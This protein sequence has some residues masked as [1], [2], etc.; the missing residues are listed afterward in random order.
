MHP[1]QK[2]ID[3]PFPY[4]CVWLL[5]RNPDGIGRGS[6]A[7]VTESYL[8]K[9]FVWHDQLFGEGKGKIIAVENEKKVGFSTF[10]SYYIYYLSMSKPN[11][12]IAVIDNSNFVFSMLRAID[13]VMNSSFDIDSIDGL[14]PVNPTKLFFLNGSSV[15]V[16][17]PSTYNIRNFDD[18]DL[19]FFDNMISIKN[20]D[21][22]I[23][24]ITLAQSTEEIKK[25]ILNIENDLTLE[26]PELKKNKIS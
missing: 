22:L 4:F 24:D 15:R 3:N 20:T 16:L 10:M 8:K 23:Y 9:W 17:K 26:F 18:L 21:K 14:R 12:T 6:N 5:S 7:S 11:S 19:V 13:V 1:F 2:E 25:I